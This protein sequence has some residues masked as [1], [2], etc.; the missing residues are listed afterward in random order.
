METF[1]FF[2]TVKDE[3][4]FLIDS[5][6][7]LNVSSNCIK[8][9]III[10]SFTTITTVKKKVLL[11]V[12]I[13]FAYCFGYAQ[14]Y[15]FRHYQ[16]ENGLSHNTVFCTLQDSRGFMWF[17]T[18][19]GLNRFDG[20]SFKIFRK[21]DQDTGSIGNNFIYSLREDDA[22]H[23]WVGTGKGLYA[24]NA[25][26]ENFRR[27]PT[28]ELSDVNEI[29]TDN[30]GNIWFLMGAKLYQYNP[31]TGNVAQIAELRDEWITSIWVTDAGIVWFTTFGTLKKYDPETGIYAS[32][33]VF[34]HSP[35]TPTK[36]I[37]KMFYA[38]NGKI[39]L[40]TT[41]Q[42]LK[43]F[44]TKDGSY[45]DVLTYNP[46][47][48]NIFVRD[49]VH[50][51]NNEYW[52]AS[53]SGIFIYDTEKGTIA[54][55]H[56][57]Y[58]DPYSLS[59]NAIYSLCRD[60]EG[61][62]WAGTYFGGVNY[63]PKQYLAFQK[64]FPDNS[65]QSISGN[66]VREICQDRYGNLWIGTEDRG[67]NKLN[68]KTGHITQY[69]PTGKPGSISYP[70]IHGLLATGNQL[71]IGTFEHGLDVMDIRTGKVIQHYN[72][73]TPGLRSNFPLS[74]YK[75]RSGELLTG[76]SISLT[77]YD[78]ISQSFIKVEQVPGDHFIYH[79][80]EDRDGTV[81]VSTIGDGLYFYNEKTGRRGNFRY[82]PQ[83]RESLGSDMVNSSFEDSN[84]NLWVATEGGGLCKL[85]KENKTFTRYTSKNGMPSDY[86]FKILED[87]RKNLWIATSRGLV[88]L[89]LTTG[90]M[91]VYTRANGLL[92]D[93]F[94][95]NSGYKNKEGKMYFGSVKG[96]ISFNPDTFSASN[97]VAPVY[98]TGL[99]V[100]NKEVQVKDEDS[101]LTKSVL[102]TRKITLPYDQSSFSIDFAALSYTAPEMTAYAYIMHG[103]DK[104][105]TPIKTNRKVYFTNLLP[106][107]YVFNVKA[108]GS[109]GGWSRQPAQL[110]IQILPPW[111]A[112]P[113]AYA[114]YTLAAMALAF[115]LVRRYHNHIEEKN[116]RKIEYLHHEKEKELYEAK[117]DF[118]TNVAHE[119][120]TPLTLIKGPLE[121]IMNQ[122][123]NR[124][125]IQKH[126]S[127][128]ER[129]TNRL[130]DLTS[131]LLD[132]RQTEAKGFRLNLS[133]M[134][135]SAL[136][137]ET[138]SN[139]K[140]LAE[141]K[142]LAYSLSLPESDLYARVDD[143]A[144]NKIYCNLF[145]NAVKY[146]QQEVKIKME[147]GPQG[148][149]TTEII[150]DGYVIPENKREK[151]FEPFYRLKGTEKQKG[152]G[153][154][155]A[156]SRSLAALHKGTLY[157]KQTNMPGYNIFVLS[158]P[159]SSKAVM[160]S[161]DNESK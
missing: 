74:L 92:N 156:L 37:E 48:T 18:K 25:E 119:I 111:W 51:T 134:N 60:K 33:D 31:V 21:D 78:S 11:L 77:R 59:D 109:N 15:Y 50:I 117:I 133:K 35:H 140:S 130:I 132:F 10:P 143:D 87:G 128:M 20:T 139:F 155:L 4:I 88:C 105:W 89:N 3:R 29:Q 57:Q 63:F 144:L 17:G 6:R 79:I 99:Q 62:I 75:T 49:F 107:T 80:M 138:F 45:T 150:S 129:N 76:T 100:N 41:G 86:I 113:W 66:A 94:N 142:N 38:G 121:K 153:I 1:P 114:L 71:W 68:P 26:K 101:P 125:E 54:N 7:R 52:I 137:R 56:K 36:W 67:L 115:Y 43:I 84:G 64:Y 19:D 148:H 28:L 40:G 118:F 85:N 124:P 73:A 22:G 39:L 147:A 136:L 65:P 96:M 104:E 149:F 46:D 69:M 116:R 122:A 95:Y 14:G 112:S 55:L 93:Q 160:E 70:N 103:A 27:V 90:K 72:S 32:Y 23:M 34:S 81:W 8:S 157:L 24:Y 47:K 16:V 146:A 159:L 13:A 108:A 110:T 127:T 2:G 102:L 120:K 91:L 30:K 44:D 106:G 154:G 161:A 98:I 145:S 83:H 158:L 152:T 126:L 58:N 61:G 42:G 151:I 141:Q 5:L 123:D 12:T 97:F 9:Q 82:D 131:Q 135:V 53:E